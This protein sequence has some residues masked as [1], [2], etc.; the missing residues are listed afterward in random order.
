MCHSAS[1]QT[2]IFVN[3][4]CYIIISTS[5]NVF[6]KKYKLF[7]SKQ[8]YLNIKKRLIKT[9]VWSVVTYGCETWIINDTEKKKLEA[10]EMCT[11]RHTE[12]IS[13]IKKKTN[14]VRTVKEKRT[15]M[16]AIRARR[17]KMVGHALRH[18]EEMHNI[19]IY[20]V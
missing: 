19:I 16:D 17:W 8:I 4:F 3:T 2:N 18:S 13:W 11:W 15:F 1:H 20:I 6:S 5:V 7:T 10:F 12:R 14:E 9:Y